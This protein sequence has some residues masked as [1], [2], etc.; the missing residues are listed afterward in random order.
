MK[1]D[2]VLGVKIRDSD[3]EKLVSKTLGIEA[4]A[5]RHEIGCKLRC[6][7]FGGQPCEVRKDFVDES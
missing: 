3:S 7:E 4:E 6:I 1:E 2:A 5:R